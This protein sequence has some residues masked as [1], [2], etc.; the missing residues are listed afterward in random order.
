MIVCK[1]KRF[2]SVFR[3]LICVLASDHVRL[4]RGFHVSCDENR[5]CGDRNHDSD[6]GNRGCGDESVCNRQHKD[7]EH[8]STD[9]LPQMLHYLRYQIQNLT[10]Y[11]GD[12]SCKVLCV[13]ENLNLCYQVLRR[14]CCFQSLQS[15]GGSVWKMSASRFSI[16]YFH[17]H[18]GILSVDR[19]DLDDLLLFPRRWGK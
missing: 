16:G 18:R 19:A 15:D 5:G 10:L 12:V 13:H 7:G 11:V 6:G 8:R 14:S 17:R 2:S 1:R 3:A 4:M 9:F